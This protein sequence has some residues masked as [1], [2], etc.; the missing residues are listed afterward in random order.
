MW[1]DSL[2]DLQAYFMGQ[3]CGC[4]RL[5]TVARGR[6]A[7][8]GEAR[9]AAWANDTHALGIKAYQLLP[10]GAP[11]Q[12]DAVHPI[13]LGG[14]CA[15]AIKSDLDGQLAKGAARLKAILEDA[16]GAP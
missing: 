9:I 11:E 6:A 5:C 12:N 14:D 4:N 2:I 1:D 7:S 16:L 8:Y 3:L 15:A 10:L 13:E